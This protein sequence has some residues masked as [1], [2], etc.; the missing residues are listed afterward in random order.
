[1][2]ITAYPGYGNCVD[3]N[4]GGMINDW[5]S[6]EKRLYTL[7]IFIVSYKSTDEVVQ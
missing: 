5:K 4:F 1:M 2:D 7:N 6:Q 3:I